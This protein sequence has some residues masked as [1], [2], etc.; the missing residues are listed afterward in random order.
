MNCW[1]GLYFRFTRRV[2]R[3]RD[4]LRLRS[5]QAPASLVK[6]QGWDNAKEEHDY[7]VALRGCTV[8]SFVPGLSHQINPPA[9]TSPIAI[10]CVPDIIPPNTEP[11]PGSSRRNFRCFRSHIRNKKFANSTAASNN[12]VGSRGTFNGVPVI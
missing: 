11:R 7:R 5:G 4:P 8:A 10:N 12:C 3:A 1:D 9:T 2:G 6:T